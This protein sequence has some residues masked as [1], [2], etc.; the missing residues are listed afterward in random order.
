MRN[1]RTASSADP[2]RTAGGSVSGARKRSLRAGA[3]GVARD[4]RT[5]FTM[6][7]RG[8]VYGR[9]WRVAIAASARCVGSIAEHCGDCMRPSR[10]AAARSS[11][12]NMQFRSAG[13]RRRGGMRTTSS[14]SPRAAGIRRTICERCAFAAIR[15]K[16]KRCACGA[17]RSAASRSPI[18]GICSIV[19]AGFWMGSTGE[20][21][22]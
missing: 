1:S 11:L 10:R 5:G 21:S 4:V 8:P 9:T 6:R 12:S 7:R 18:G 16:R 2:A 13:E 3:S 14:R 17:S 22:F 15:L 20:R 19:P